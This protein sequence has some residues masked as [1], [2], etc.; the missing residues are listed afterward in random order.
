MRIVAADLRGSGRFAP[1][2]PG[3]FAEKVLDIDAIPQFADWRGINAQA[4]VAGRFASQPH[5][6]LR[7]EFRLWD[8][9]TGQQL[10]GRQY[11][12]A[13]DRW[14]LVAHLIA[15]AIYERLTGQAGHFEE[16]GRN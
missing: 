11:A 15:D 4:L 5:G 16:N 7:V 14:R 1:I 13:A 9:A 12:V 2:D 10:S 6:R 3:T 8:V